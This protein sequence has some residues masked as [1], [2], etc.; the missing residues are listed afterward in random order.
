MHLFHPDAGVAFLQGDVSLALGRAGFVQRPQGLFP[1]HAVLLE[2]GL[3]LEALHRVQGVASEASVRG[4]GQIAQLAQGGLQLFHPDARVPALELH[5]GPVFRRVLIVQGFQSGFG[6]HAA[7]LEAGVALEIAQRP[8][9]IRAEHPVGLS[10]I[11][12]QLVQALLHAAHRISLVAPL[13]LV[14]G[15]LGFGGGMGRGFRGGRGIHG[16]LGG[17][18]IQNPFGPDGAAGDGQAG[19]VAGGL[20]RDVFHA[21]GELGLGRGGL[22]G[23]LGHLGCESAQ[24]HVIRPIPAEVDHQIPLGVGGVALDDDVILALIRRIQDVAVTGRVVADRH[25]KGHILLNAAGVG[26][27]DLGQGLE[28]VKAGRGKSLHQRGGHHEFL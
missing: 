25:H 11:I 27:G 9:G 6:G 17:L 16:F 13:E 18:G 19:K 24:A 14:I 4:T 21:V 12:A 5:I 20:Q 1:G 3:L 26:A 7:L 2:A 15:L 8:L 23:V 10:A 28:R 22:G